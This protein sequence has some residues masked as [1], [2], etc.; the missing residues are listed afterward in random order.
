MKSIEKDQKL[1][2]RIDLLLIKI[3]QLIDLLSIKIDKLIK[4]DGL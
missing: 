1:I 2:D 3:Y 4:L